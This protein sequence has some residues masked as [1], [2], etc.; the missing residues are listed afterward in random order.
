MHFVEVEWDN[1]LFSEMSLEIFWVII[2]IYFNFSKIF[3]NICFGE[4]SLE[5]FR[6]ILLMS[7][8]VADQFFLSAH[9]PLLQHES[10]W[11]LITMLGMSCKELETSKNVLRIWGHTLHSMNE[12]MN[13]IFRCSSVIH[14]MQCVTPNSEHI[15]RYLDNNFLM[16]NPLS[17]L[18]LFNAVSFSL[19]NGTFF[20][21]SAE[22]GIW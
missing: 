7:G 17:F 11:N 22:V 13:P 14:T 8:N 3:V 15:Y 21:C 20:R 2:L 9:I 4:M 1:C 16:N 10:T 6:V 19:N 5:I 18:L 12:W